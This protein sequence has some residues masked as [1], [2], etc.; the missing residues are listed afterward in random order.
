LTDLAN[1]DKAAKVIKVR[2]TIFSFFI[3]SF[4]K[5]LQQLEELKGGNSS[6]RGM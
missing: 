3:I 1:Q 5:P 2:L 6:K 4:K